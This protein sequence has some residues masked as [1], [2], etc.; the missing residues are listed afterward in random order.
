MA[1]RRPLRIGIT[2]GDINGIGP[3][4]SLR[5]LHE[6]SW[7][8]TAGFVLI[9][10]AEAARAVA[11]RLGL[12]PPEPVEGPEPRRMPPCALWTPP[13]SPAIRPVPGRIRVDAARAAVVWVE[14]AVRAALD[15]RLD[16]VVT[17]PICKEGLARAGFE[18]PGH[19]EL[20]ARLCGV[21][22]YAMLLAGGGLRVGLATRHLPLRS[23]PDAVTRAAIVEAATLVALALPWLGAPNGAVA[24]CGLNPHAGDG[25]ALGSEDRAVILPAIRALRRRGV[26]VTGP[27]AADT[28]F[29]EALH[30][31]HAAVLAM[32]HDQGLAPLKTV[33]FDTGV[34]LTLGLPIVRTSP[35]HGT[36]FDLAGRGR[37]SPASM[38]AAIRMAVDL[39]G[40]KNPWARTR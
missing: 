37:A 34:N 24:V 25:G 11:R 19:T 7:P 20:I 13:G 33:A 15:G 36:A 31:R 39:A 27:H 6:S 18:Y 22:R 28:V 17:A 4:V 30:G 38:K 2:L 21:R 26:R 3:E 40:R 10:H 1:A 35:D 9:G 23:V 5:A 8:A 32:Y 14:A 16:A 12:P 29:H